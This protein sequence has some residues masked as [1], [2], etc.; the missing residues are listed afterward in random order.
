MKKLI[1]TIT[2]SLLIFSQAQAQI[3]LTSVISAIA[4]TN[5]SVKIVAPAS[6]LSLTLPRATN[7]SWDM[8]SLDYS[9]GAGVYNHVVIPGGTPFGSA[10]YAD[11]VTYEIS[12]GSGIGYASDEATQASA[13]GLNILGEYLYHQHISLSGVPGG[14]P[15]DSLGFPAQDILYSSPRTELKFPMTYGT[16]WTT[17]SRYTTNFTVTF[18]FLS[19]SGVPA[20]RVTSY[21]MQDSV[22]GW[23]K[24]KVKNAAG[25]TTTYMDVLQVKTIHT[26]QDSFYL[27]G[28]PASPTLLAGFGLVQG[29]ITNLFEENFYRPNEVTPLLKVE[30]SD[31]TYTTP[32]SGEVHMQ[33]LAMP[34]AVENLSLANDIKV[35]PNPVTDHNISI[36]LP[37]S[38][39]ISWN[40]ELINVAGQVVATSSLQPNNGHVSIQL[41]SAITPGL[42]YLRLNNENK[43][44]CIKALNFIN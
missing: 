19:L 11:S 18:A 36:D 6:I 7:N 5:D 2:S 31:S 13:A 37:K 4:G 24:M 38:Q 26:A 28:S 22:I 20:Q 42:Y 14:G 15:D 29:M 44:T 39:N 17:T 9:S 33:R 35:Y 40:Y 25:D 32:V 34:T 8:T 21:T 1:F 41:S 16:N 10:Q 12:S 30:Y 23:G 3:T 43:Q 27:A